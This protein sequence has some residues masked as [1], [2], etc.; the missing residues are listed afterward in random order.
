MFVT[1]FAYDHHTSLLFI[2][3]VV[4]KSLANGAKIFGHSCAMRI[5]YILSMGK[6]IT[7]EVNMDKLITV[8]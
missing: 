2:G 4:S 7:V 3:S 1:S 6:M 8:E 5:N